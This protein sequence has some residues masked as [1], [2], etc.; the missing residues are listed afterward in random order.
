MIDHLEIDPLPR[1]HLEMLGDLEYTIHYLQG[2]P[3]LIRIDDYCTILNVYSIARDNGK[4]LF[5]SLDYF[6]DDSWNGQVRIL[7]GEAEED[8][9]MTFMRAKYSTYDGY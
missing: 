5:I 3:E 4:K 9:V 7:A 8:D 6:E 2:M 1:D